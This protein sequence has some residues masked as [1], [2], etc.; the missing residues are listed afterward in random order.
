MSSKKK[1]PAAAPSE[2]TK[3]DEFYRR[4]PIGLALAG[5]L[6]EL[7]ADGTLETGANS[8]AGDVMSDF[9]EV[10]RRFCWCGFIYI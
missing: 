2:M 1:V 7:M 6:H 5:A 8:I 9:D 3:K 4:A 10:S